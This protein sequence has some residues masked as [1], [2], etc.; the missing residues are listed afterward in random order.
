MHKRFSSAEK[1]TTN[2]YKS[3]WRASG[4]G[5]MEELVAA[6]TA[7]SARNKIKRYMGIPKSQQV[8][9]VIYKK[10]KAPYNSVMALA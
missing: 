5:V 6:A 2:I 3:E 4:R 7:D 9:R 1:L 10:G 8:V